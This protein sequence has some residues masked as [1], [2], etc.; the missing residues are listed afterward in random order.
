MDLMITAH[1]KSNYESWKTIFDGDSAR[2]EFC[3]ESK[4][5]VSKVDDTTAL[6]VLFDV[7]KPKMEA[8]LSSPEFEELVKDHVKS[9]DIYTLQGVG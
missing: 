8:R 1:L 6:I 9:H 7:D 3:N 5:M 4:T 2:A